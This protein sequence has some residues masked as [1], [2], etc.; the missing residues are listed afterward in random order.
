MPREGYNVVTIPE[1]VHHRLAESARIEN[2]SIPKQIEHMLKKQYPGL[3]HLE[4]AMCK[5]CGYTA[6]FDPERNEA[7]RY[8]RSCGASIPDAGRERP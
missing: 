2:R 4:T 7:P 3:S 8:C 6:T 5:A 1:N